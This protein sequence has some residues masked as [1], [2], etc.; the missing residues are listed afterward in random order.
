MKRI[1][2]IDHPIHS[3]V[4]ITYPNFRTQIFTRGNYQR[5]TDFDGVGR[6]IRT[7]EKDTNI[8]KQIVNRKTYDAAGRV[9]FT[10]YPSDILAE[11]KGVDFTYDALSRQQTVTNN[12]DNTL[13]VYTYIS[14]EKTEVTNAR[15]YMTTYTYR[16]FGN[17]DQKE[18]VK[19]EA[20]EFITTDINRNLLGQVTSITQ[21]SLIRSYYYD[22]K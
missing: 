14:P 13:T 17:P 15:N 21:G 16:I 18:L 6:E 7:I 10:A 12:Q 2:S 1:T 22:N 5:T 8:N 9:T 19:I 11:T 4:T 3:D 20:P